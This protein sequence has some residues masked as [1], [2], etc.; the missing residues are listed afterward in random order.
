M[1]FLLFFC[2]FSGFSRGPIPQSIRVRSFQVNIPDS[3]PL[4][5][6]L[7]SFK[8]RLKNNLVMLDWATPA[9]TN[10][11]HFVIQRSLDGLDFNDDAIVFTDG[12]GSGLKKYSFSD[13]IKAI[14][15][16]QIFYR[17]KMVAMDERYRYSEVISLRLQSD[18]EQALLLNHGHLAVIKYDN[19]IENKSVSDTCLPV[20]LA[21]SDLPPPPGLHFFKQQMP[22][23]LSNKNYYNKAKI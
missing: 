13:N 9:Q 6:I 10:T 14:Y 1:T 7:V 5:S 8:A 19:F 4:P 23:G 3:N 17:L 21:F 16:R 15:S 12:T 2:G 20:A 22:A 11:S 18:F